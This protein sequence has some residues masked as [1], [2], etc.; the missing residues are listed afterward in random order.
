MCIQEEGGTCCSFVNCNINRG[1]GQT[2][3]SGHNIMFF[4]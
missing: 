3:S 2:A 4:F 1:G